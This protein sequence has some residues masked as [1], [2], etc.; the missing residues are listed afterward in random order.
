LWFGPD[1]SLYVNEL[2]TIALKLAG[3][4]AGGQTDALPVALPDMPARVRKVSPTGTVSIVAGPGGKVLTDPDADDALY[5]PTSLAI[6]GQG[7]L[8]IIDVGANQIKIL[9]AGSY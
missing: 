6:D 5:A 7:R 3:G 2:G 1:G 9:P 8:A 4:V